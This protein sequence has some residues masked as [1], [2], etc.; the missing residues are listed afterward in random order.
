MLG[1]SF[2]EAH[3]LALCDIFIPPTT[4]GLTKAPFAVA[5]IESPETSFT[6]REFC[7]R[8]DFTQINCSIILGR[9]RL[10]VAGSRTCLPLI[11]I[12]EKHVRY[13]EASQANKYDL[14]D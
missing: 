4:V 13:G 2:P 1:C 12:N 14:H 9:A 8:S 10:P 11:A 7:W 5:A 3:L 6:I